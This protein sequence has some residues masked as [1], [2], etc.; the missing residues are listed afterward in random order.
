MT[1]NVENMKEYEEI[2]R[3]IGFGTP[4]FV[5]ALG[6]GKI[7]RPSFLLGYRTCKNSVYLFL[8]YFRGLYFF[9]T[10]FSKKSPVLFLY[11]GRVWGPKNKMPVRITACEEICEKYEEISRNM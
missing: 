7:P 2:R 11:G 3:Y 8:R 4:I 5:W 9:F 10:N 6:L 1:E